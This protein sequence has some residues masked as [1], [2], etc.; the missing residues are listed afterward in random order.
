M[1]VIQ[2][3]GAKKP[4]FSWCENPEQNALDQITAIAK[5]PFVEHCAWMADGH[6]GNFC[7]IGGVVATNGVVVPNFVGS[8]CGC[9]M[10]ACKTSLKSDQLDNEEVRNRIHNSVERGI[11]MGF[12]H[13]TQDRINELKRMY[14]QRVSYIF[15]KSKI[16]KTIFGLANMDESEKMI[17]SALATLGS[18]N[19]FCEIQECPEDKS[20][21][22]MIHSGSRNI[23]AKLCDR[24]ND[25]AISM[26]TLWHSIDTNGIPFLPTS[27]QEGHDYLA[28]MEFALRFAYLNRFGILDEIK[29]DM[30]HIFPTITFEKETNIHHNYVVQENHFGKNWFIHRKGA[31]EAREKTIGI[32]PGSMGTSSYIVKGLGNVTSLS[33]CSHGSGRIMSRTEFNNQF[34]NESGVVKIKESMKGIT[35]TKFGKST[36]RKGKDTGMMD[37]SEAPQAYKNIE[38]IIKNQSDLVTP[39]VRLIPR[40]NWKDTGNRDE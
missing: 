17:Y 13:N 30:E 34:N 37:F 31:T 4:L 40:I 29:K 35:H 22:I 12:S 28:W 32:I 1:Q 33:S 8:D 25:L 23:G 9:G 2:I 36:S 19:H 27:S 21:W 20:V 10:L 14:S 7:P 38:D 11:P 5:L 39:I 3:E 26:N 15:E 6:M 24:F 18:G 16:D